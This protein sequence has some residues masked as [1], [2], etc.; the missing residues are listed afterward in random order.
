M[1][2]LLCVEAFEGE[3]P[4][5]PSALDGSFP[6]L[7]P[8][9]NPHRASSLPQGFLSQEERKQEFSALTCALVLLAGAPNYLSASPSQWPNFGSFPTI[10]VLEALFLGI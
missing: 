8:P 10:Q 7:L 2:Q 1:T 4:W 3:E 9:G 5:T 6:S